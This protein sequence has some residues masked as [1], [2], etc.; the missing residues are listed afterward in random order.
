MGRINQAKI[1][2]AT[3]L[4]KRVINLNKAAAPGFSYNLEFTGATRGLY[5]YKHKLIN[6]KTREYEPVF[7]YYCYLDEDDLADTLSGVEAAIA[8]EEQKIKEEQQ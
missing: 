1:E 8:A 5:F 4:L 3:E 7:M 2:K 6:P